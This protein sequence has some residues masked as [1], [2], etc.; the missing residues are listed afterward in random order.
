[1]AE[2]LVNCRRRRVERAN[3]HAALWGRAA[4][5]QFGVAYAREHERV[6]KWQ[7]SCVRRDGLARNPEQ[8]IVR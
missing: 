3:L 1:M 6:Q 2:H 8:A 5:R 7:M 4:G